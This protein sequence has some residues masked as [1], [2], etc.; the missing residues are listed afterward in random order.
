MKP[1]IEEMDG[2]HYPLMLE[3][4]KHDHNWMR[5]RRSFSDQ[6]MKHYNQYGYT[7][8]DKEQ[9]QLVYDNNRCEFSSL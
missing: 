8:L 4:S 9:M 3:M 6:Q 2:V 1:E 7:F 5:A